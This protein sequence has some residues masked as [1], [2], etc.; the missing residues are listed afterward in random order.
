MG[1][2]WR[3]FYTHFFR[4]MEDGNGIDPVGSFRALVFIADGNEKW[5]ANILNHLHDTILLICGALLHSDLT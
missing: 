2:R 4:D 3:L 5:I 1:S